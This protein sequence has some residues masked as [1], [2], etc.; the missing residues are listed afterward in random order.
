MVNLA[1]CMPHTGAIKTKTVLSLCKMF[2]VLPFEYNLITQE[3]SVLFLNRR[4]LVKKAQEMNATHLLFI[5]TDMVFEPDAVLKLLLHK[6]DI[7]GVHVNCRG[8]PLQTT[9][10]M[11]EEQKK[12][13]NGTL[14]KC[15]A[16]G[17]GFMLIN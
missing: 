1:V 4:R 16:V 15:D 8:F 2:K 17:T 13:M 6:K 11:T 14:A 9:V 10:R 5:D 7:I 3:G 12:A